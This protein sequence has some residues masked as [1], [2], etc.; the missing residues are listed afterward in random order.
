MTGLPV[1]HTHTNE[2]QHAQHD[3][4]MWELDE[5]MADGAVRSKPKR[6]QISIS[7]PNREQLFELWSRTL[8]RARLQLCCGDSRRGVWGTRVFKSHHPLFR[9]L[10]GTFCTFWGK[11]DKGQGKAR[12]VAAATNVENSENTPGRRRR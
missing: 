4:V 11:G 12:K 3:N 7:W 6:D 1:W 10:R 2:A 5:R 9:L 8:R